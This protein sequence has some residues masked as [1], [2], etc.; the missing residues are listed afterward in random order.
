MTTSLLQLLLQL[1][2]CE[3]L[4]SDTLLQHFMLWMGD[5]LCEKSGAVKT[6][7]TAFGF[8]KIMPVKTSG[9]FIKGKWTPPSKTSMGSES[10]VL[11]ICFYISSLLPCE[12]I[13]GLVAGRECRESLIWCGLFSLSS[14]IFLFE[15]GTQSQCLLREKPT[16][17]D[18]GPSVNFL[19]DVLRL[20]TRSWC[21]KSQLHFHV[22][23][24]LKS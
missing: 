23:L 21:T 10:R 17:K 2:T 22:Q 4:V 19:G 6:C 8:F 20:S 13:L 3:H 15:M 11:G 5:G 9:G 12:R 24:S 7:W 16:Q 18:Q 14:L 1:L